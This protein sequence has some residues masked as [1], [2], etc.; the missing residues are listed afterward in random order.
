MIQQH[1]T[2]LLIIALPKIGL[3]IPR[4]QSTTLIAALIQQ[5]KCNF[6][7]IA[8]TLAHFIGKVYIIL[9]MLPFINGI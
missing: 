7:A 4:Y 5:I 6:A 8:H 3:I 2:K 1:H 9:N